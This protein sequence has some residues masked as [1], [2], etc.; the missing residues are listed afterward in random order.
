MIATLALILATAGAA[1]FQMLDAGKAPKAVYRYAPEAGSVQTVRLSMSIDMEMSMAGMAMPA[2]A[3]PTVF[4]ELR[5]EVTEVAKD[6]IHYAYSIVEAGAEGEGPVAD[7]LRKELGEAVGSGGAVTLDG[8]G[9]LQGTTAVSQPTEA[10][11]VDQMEATLGKLALVLPEGAVGQGASWRLEE[12]RFDGGV[13]VHQISTWTL[14]EIRADGG[15]VIDVAV[16]QTAEDQTMQTSAGESEL[17]G[18]ASSASGRT[19]VHP[20]RILPIEA[21]MTSSTE[22]SAETKMGDNPMTVKTKMGQR[23]TL[24]EKK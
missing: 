24:T 19:I 21:E 8:R 20:G 16:T 17:K 15:L 6:R 13:A 3:V 10:T 14:A 2:M 11:P 1:D 12:D 23:T 5:S 9:Q 7:E 4:Y 22:V 18:F